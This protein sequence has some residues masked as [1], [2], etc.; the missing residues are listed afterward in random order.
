[1]KTALLFSGQATQYV[2]MGRYLYDRYPESRAIF[3]AADE[4]LGESLSSLIFEG[5]E[6]KLN[7]TVNTQPAVL[8]VAL[9][10]WAILDER[11]FKP[12]V[13]AGHSL[14]EY[15]AL[16]CAGVLSFED[17][18]RVCKRRGELMQTAVP[19]GHGAMIIVQRLDADFIRTTCRNVE[20]YADISVYNAPKLVAVSGEKAAVERVA[21]KL[22]EA[23]GI[24][25]PLAVSA[26]FH[27]E[28]LAPA[29][30]GLDLALADI[31]L[32]ALE[33]PYI[34]NVDAQW[35]EHANPETI[36]RHL[37][38]QV[39]SPVRWEES[40]ALMMSN[41]IERFW[42][43]GPGRSNLTHVKKQNRKANV[44]SFDDINA[45]HELLEGNLD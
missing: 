42:H 8:T 31:S 22:T 6:S 39:V 15:A 12:S 38:R 4:I 35:I 30:K 16:V 29:A 20:G 34:N 2:G 5:P 43:L 45:V 18:L 1:M 9:A 26:P 23:R 7:L 27:C 24:V 25:R 44:L 17:A 37:V 28:L 11:G 41:G 32:R 13:V 19:E 40:I 36:K 10:A 21:E 14:G 33:I 3:E